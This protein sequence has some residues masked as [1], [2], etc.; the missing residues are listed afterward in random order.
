MQRHRV[1]AHRVAGSIRLALAVFVLGGAVVVLGGAAL[2]SLFGTSSGFSDSL[3]YVYG[4]MLSDVG[5]IGT[6]PSVH[7]PWWV[8]GVIGLAGAV[9]VLTAATVLFRATRDSRTLGVADE[10]KVRAMLRDFGD[11]DSLGYFATRRDKSVVW[12]TGDVTT[13]RA[14]V[15]YRVIGSVSLASGNPVGDPA[16]WPEAIARW[17]Q[18]ARDNGWSLAVMGAGHAGALAFADAAGNLDLILLHLV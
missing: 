5:R 1:V 9:V 18:E 16:R 3:A 6:D 13:A 10:A 7:A 15:S 14:G 17:Q 12:E 2:V 4:A 11:H 8:R